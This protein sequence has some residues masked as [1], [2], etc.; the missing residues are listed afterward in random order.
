MIRTIP[1]IVLT[2]VLAV[3][4]LG[5][6]C[7]DPAS[8]GIDLSRQAECDPLVPEKCLLP[9]PNDHYTVADGGTRTRRRIAFAPN[10]LPK[11]TM[12]TPLETAELNKNDGFS[13]GAAAIL[14]MP[15]VDVAL[16][17]VP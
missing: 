14:W 12:G 7:V 10:A 15:G 3:P 8:L 5:A 1:Q 16:S 6:P 11:N 13:P 9:F 4:A 17:D 2:A